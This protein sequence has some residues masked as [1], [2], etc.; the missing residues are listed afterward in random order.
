MQTVSKGKKA[1]FTVVETNQHEA[2]RQA[3]TRKPISSRVRM[4]VLA[5]SGMA[6]LLLAPVVRGEQAPRLVIFDN[7]FWGPAGTNLQAAA[8]LLN[9]NGVKPL[10]LTV[11][12]GDGWRDED[13]AHTLRLLEILGQTD[14][15]VVPGAVFPLVNTKVKQ[16]AWEKSFGII[17]WK[18]AW[19]DPKEGLFPDYKSHD[20]FEVPHLAEGDPTIKAANEVAADFLIRQVH[21]YP[22]QVT[23]VAAG[24]LT[25]LA[26]A[27]RLDPEFASL[28]K[29][30]I[31][32][33]GLIG[34]ISKATGNPDFGSDFN[35]IFDPEAA[36]IVLTADWPAITAVGDVTN[37]TMLTDDLV[38][39]IS[40]KKTPLTEYVAKYTE[41][42]VPLWDELTVG[43]FVDPT[44]VTKR[45]AVAMDIDL[46]HGPGYGSARI[47]SDK[48]APHLGE[49]KVNI[50]EEVDVKR[51][52][53]QFVTA[54][55]ATPA[56]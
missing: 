11:V 9:S 43:I 45:T 22:H 39:R 24:P 54:M 49:R 51:F 16:Q 37:E 44:L 41:P 32:M 48:V 1:A 15:P 30:L 52:I 29:E 6:A 8:L 56:K 17:P 27:I 28:A 50:V 10:G 21:Q 47:W 20:P 25:N 35:L 55:Q 34:G 14:I 31:F 26:L 23:I 4:M 7:D 42:G 5:C 36:E 18:G 2:K 33:G 19:N 3:R 53:D 12:T 40:E 46:S 13:V 38:K